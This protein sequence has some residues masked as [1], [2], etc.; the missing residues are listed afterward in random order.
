MTYA[1]SSI[2]DCARVVAPLKNWD[3]AEDISDAVSCPMRDEGVELNCPF[4]AA[5]TSDANPVIP[6]QVV[7][8]EDTALAGTVE[9]PEGTLEWKVVSSGS[10]WLF[11]VREGSECMKYS[12]GSGPIPDDCPGTPP[13]TMSHPM[14]RYPSK[15]PWNWLALNEE[16]P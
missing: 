11:I 3:L 1:G 2:T 5:R 16:R 10:S 13:V 8:Y 12:V 4:A 15:Y 14:P 6:V 7:A 9:A